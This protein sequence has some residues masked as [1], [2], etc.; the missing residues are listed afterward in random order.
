MSSKSSV[1]SW[2]SNVKSWFSSYAS[3]SAFY[4]IGKDV[5]DGFNRGINDFYDL[6]LPYMRKWAK[7]AER[8]FKKE[9]DSNSPSK[10]YMGIGKDTVLGYNLGIESTMN[11]TSDVINEWADSFTN[12]TPTLSF[13]V[14]TSALKYY[15][16]DSFAKSVSASVTSKASVTTDGFEE[17]LIEFYREYIEPT[18]AQMAADMRRQADKNEQTVVQIGNRVVSDAVNTQRKANGYVFAK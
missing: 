9:L 14:D 8:E 15:D 16:S 2:A 11:S 4:Y 18:M 13:G 3:Y 6:T 1:T 17:G 10:V 7:E 5:I 12:I